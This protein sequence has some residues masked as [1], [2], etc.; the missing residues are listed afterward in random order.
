MTVNY[1]EDPGRNQLPH[2][3]TLT[4]SMQIDWVP[5]HV[6]IDGKTKADQEAKSAAIENINPVHPHP[7][8]SLSKQNPPSNRTGAAEEL[9]EW[10]RYGGTSPKRTKSSTR[11]YE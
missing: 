1:Q 10:K 8:I 9:G 7:D 5:G 6:G 3:T 11:I 4:Y 2:L